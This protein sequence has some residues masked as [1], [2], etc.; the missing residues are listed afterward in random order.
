[1]P[2]DIHFDILVRDKLSAH[3]GDGLHHAGG[4]VDHIFSDVQHIL[5]RVQYRIINTEHDGERQQRRQAAARGA[6]ALFI[7]QLLQFFAV[8]LPVVPVFLLQ[9]FGLCLHLRLCGHILLL[10]DIRGEHQY[11]QDHRKDDDRHT[12]VPDNQIQRPEQITQDAAKKI[13]DF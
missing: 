10:L 11:T 5:Q 13:K 6:D 1:M 8:L 4:L 2:N 12:V 7:I 3:T 9:F